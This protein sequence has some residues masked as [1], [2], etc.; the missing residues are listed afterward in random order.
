MRM[1]AVLVGLL[2]GGVV[3]STEAAQA[4]TNAQ[5]RPAEAT[6]VCTLQVSGMT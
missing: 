2:S 5:S 6:K 1:V 4:T 3:G